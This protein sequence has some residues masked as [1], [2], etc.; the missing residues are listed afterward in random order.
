MPVARAS[1]PSVLVALVIG[2]VVEVKVHIGGTLNKHLRIKNLTISGNQTADI[3][4][5]F[6]L[7]IPSST[8]HLDQRNTFNL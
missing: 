1:L 3:K 5:S 7:I 2:L 4:N 8:I 6:E